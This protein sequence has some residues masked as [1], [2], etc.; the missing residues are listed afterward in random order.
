M[1]GITPFTAFDVEIDA[2]FG[3]KGKMNMTRILMVDDEKAFLNS[4]RSKLLMEGYHD[5]TPVQDSSLV[6]E[7]LRTNDFDAAFLDIAMPGMDGMELLEI[8]KRESPQTE[9][10]MITALDDIPLVIKA[11]RLGALDYLVKP[12]T[13]DQLICSLEKALEHKHMY[14][15]IQVGRKRDSEVVLENE[16]AFAEVVTGDDHMLRLLRE[17]ELHAK[18]DIPVLITGETGTGKELLA[19]AIHKAGSRSGKNFLAVNMPSISPELFEASFCGHVR[20]SFT[21]AD[22]DAEGFLTQAEGGTLFLDEIGDMSMDVQGKLLRI[23]QEG[24]YFTLGMNKPR[25]ADVRFIAATNCNLAQQVGEGR[26][27]KDLY[28]RLRYACLHLP[29]LRERKG[30]I[31]LLAARFLINSRRPEAILSPEAE[32]LLLRHDWPGNIR[33][34]KGVLEAAVNLADSVKILSTHLNLGPDDSM[35][36]GPVIGTSVEPLAEVERRHILVV[37]ELLDCNKTQAALALGLSLTTLQRRL[38]T[39]GVS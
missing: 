33:E 16:S 13:P 25:R 28:Y 6:P 31:R 34:L 5:L 38:K 10:I 29:P 32:A 9:C 3:I 26:F 4:M 2:A 11:V 12:V 35:Q 1:R 20:G 7:L 8:I 17:G 24:E 19:R 36:E 22:R 37:Y 15:L 27:R 23:L 39:Y 18:S 21:G 14:D 30:D